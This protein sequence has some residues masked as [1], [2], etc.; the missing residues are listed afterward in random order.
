[1]NCLSSCGLFRHDN[2]T[3]LIATLL[4][5][6]SNS[7]FQSIRFVKNRPF[8]SLVVM[9][10]FLAEKNTPQCTQLKAIMCRTSTKTVTQCILQKL[11]LTYYLNIS[12]QV[13]NLLHCRIESNRNFFC[14]NWNALA[15]N[16]LPA[17]L[18]AYEW[19]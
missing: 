9:Q 13:A 17:V 16:N 1:M 2:T 7:R 8:D 12:V 18:C 6:H 15:V 19:A 14:P 11:L 4:V 10:F 5:E 3:G